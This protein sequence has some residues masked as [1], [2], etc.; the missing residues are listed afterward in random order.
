MAKRFR[1]IE[2]F[3]VLRELNGLA[4]T[5]ANKS[6]AVGCYDLIVN[7]IVSMDIPP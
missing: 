6:I 4:D 5:A 7:S 3:H 1:K 2:F